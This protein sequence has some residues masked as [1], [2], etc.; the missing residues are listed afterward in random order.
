VLLQ[1]LLLL[2]LQLL[3]LPMLLLRLLLLGILV[4]LFWYPHRRGNCSFH[5]WWCHPFTSHSNLLHLRLKWGGLTSCC[6]TI[7][8]KA[9]RQAT[10]I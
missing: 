6:P 3:L 8:F 1:V 9:I 2:L 10:I 5:T 4:L 7:A